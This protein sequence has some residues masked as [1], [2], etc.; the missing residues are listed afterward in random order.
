MRAW[1]RPQPTWHT[2][3]VTSR[4]EK[5]RGYMARLNPGGGPR[6]AVR[7]GLYVPRPGRS[8]ADEI[9]A[10]LEI[11]PT[12]SHLIIGGIGSGKTTQLIVACDRLNKLGDTRAEYI[13][14]S[15][16]HD[17]SHMNPGTLIIAA[18]LAV[19]QLLGDT[20]DKAALA[21]AEQFRRWGHGHWRRQWIPYDDSSYGDEPP[22]DD[23]DD[24]PPPGYYDTVEE[25]PL[26]SSPEKPLDSS[27]QEKANQL[28]LL[29]GGLR[30]RFPHLVLVFDSLDRLSDPSAF[31]T[32]VEED[33]RAIQRAGM[34]VVLVGPLRSMFGPHRAVTDHFQHFYPQHA[35]DVQRDEPGRAF[36]V[37]ILRKR[38][39]PD[40]LPDSACRRLAE[41]SGG[42][43]RDLLS[44]ARAAGEEAYMRVA[45]RV[46]DDH[47]NAIADAFGRQLIY[48]LKPAE[49]EIL[50]HV[51][52]TGT[53]VPLSDDDLA[54]LV[55]RRVL[56]YRSGGSRFALHPTLEPLLAQIGPGR[57]ATT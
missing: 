26:L 55:T 37:E 48:G 16:V 27:V 28:S 53:F 51:Q 5:F 11:D 41:L 23:Y 34:G 20:D 10:R 7:D 14:V 2:L 31:A 19:R 29:R 52:Q 21:A 32:L 49:I 1:T 33:V 25:K 13:D 54:L 35:V 24:E 40:L 9:A 39:P 43:L 30:T 38:A 47:I 36:L 6:G 56:E 8:M 42:V 45:D 22:D 44:L 3:L 17:M 18:G 12:S 46:E 57:E 4:L 50:R 15:L